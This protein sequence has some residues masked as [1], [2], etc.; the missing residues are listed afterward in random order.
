MA[1]IKIRPLHTM[2][3]MREIEKVQQT[4]WGSSDLEIMPAH[5]FHALAFNGASLLG[6]YDG[7]R[8]V[9]FVFG[10]L[11][12]INTPDRVDQVAAARLKMYSVVAGVLSEYQNQ[13][14]GYKLKLAQREY[15]LKIGI[16]LITWTYDP[17]ES[18]NARF[19]IGKLGVVCHRY[20][21][22]FHGDMGGRNAGLATDRFEAEWWVTSNRVEGRVVKQRQSLSLESLVG[23]GAVLLN[24]TSFDRDGFSNPPR[25]WRSGSDRNLVLVEIPADFQSMK[26]QNFD[27]ALRWREHSRQLFEELFSQNFMV[28]D[29]VF[30]KDESNQNRSF[31]LLTHKDS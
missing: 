11:G 22:N 1:E 13:G 16:R 5:E 29:F 31:Y 24:E 17:L 20:F 2:A 8:L 14:V 26:K 9:G 12:L 18:L 10:V 25:S 19:N 4:I 7:T 21:R 27:L 3:E 15:A 30:H 23:G 28:T 6:A